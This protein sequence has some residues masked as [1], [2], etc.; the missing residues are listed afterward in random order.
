[1]ALLTENNRQY[2]SGSQTFTG[3]GTKFEFSTTFN[4]PLSKDPEDNYKVYVAYSGSLVYQDWTT[5]TTLESNGNIRLLEAN[6]AT[7]TPPSNCS[8]VIQLKSQT[9][10]NYGNRDAYGTAVEENYGSYSYIKLDDVISNFLI[11]YVGSGKIVSDVKRTD[12][13]FFAKRAL[14]EFSYDTLKSMKSQELTIPPNLSVPIPQDYVNYVN[15]SWIDGS[16]VKHPIYPTTL[17]SNPYTTP[18]QDSN[19][20]PTQDADNNNLKGT[21]ITEQRWATNGLKNINNEI[22]EELPLQH[23]GGIVTNNGFYGMDTQT[24]QVNGWFTINDAEG[25]I[26]FS[27][28][29]VDRIIILEYISDGLAIDRDTRVPK[30]AEEAM[31]AYILHAIVS[32]RANQPEYLVQRLKREKSTK[33]RNTKIRLSNLKISE[34]IQVMR[35]KSKQLKH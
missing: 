24:S 5:G 32:T 1:M 31:Y 17:T 4:T 6:G 13:L 8:I 18:I 22:Q 19:G 16:G 20:I 28:D 35:G 30:L 27:N 7:Y 3:D 21:S 12:V 25:K 9:G 2:Y 34:L 11:A 10:G 15:I 26:S 33:L 29:L 23:N 14:Q